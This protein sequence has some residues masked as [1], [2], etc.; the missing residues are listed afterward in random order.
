MKQFDGFING[1]YKY[2]SSVLKAKFIME[3][4]FNNKFCCMHSFNYDYLAEEDAVDIG[5]QVLQPVP[6]ACLK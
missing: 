4:L 6:A 1:Q 5:R 3:G 2:S